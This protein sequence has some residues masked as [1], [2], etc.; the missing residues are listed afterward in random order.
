MLPRAVL[1]GIGLQVASL[2]TGYLST[3]YL[4]YAGW[5]GVL[6]VSVPLFV[7]SLF[8]L[9]RAPAPLALRLL[10]SFWILSIPCY[11][12]ATAVWEFA[13]MRS[14]IVLM[15]VGTHGKVTIYFQDPSGAPVETEGGRL[16]LRI[17][18]KGELRTRARQPRLASDWAA[19]MR[20]D[21]REYY[22]AGPE[23][24]RVRLPVVGS[25]DAALLPAN[26]ICVVWPGESYDDKDIFTVDFHVGTP[27]QIEDSIR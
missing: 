20:R 10:L 12:V 8:V 26:Q 19:S 17:G 15:P 21:R 5:L 23:G 25:F 9:L 1:I 22:L 4:Y 6:I 27:R 24:Q 13:W 7:A 16:V 14:E 11:Y 2:V 3:R 18:E